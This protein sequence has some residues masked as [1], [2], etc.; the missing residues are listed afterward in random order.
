M[1]AMTAKTKNRDQRMLLTSSRR[2][3][4]VLPAVVLV[5]IAVLALVALS[6]F[7]FR[8]EPGPQQVATIQKELPTEPIVKAEKQQTPEQ[9]TTTE[10]EPSKQQTTEPKKEVVPQQ[11]KTPG[12]PPRSRRSEEPTIKLGQ[13]APDFELPRLTIEPDSQ[14]KNIGKVS[15]ET[16][17]LS[18]FRGKKPAFLIFSSYT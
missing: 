15:T 5:L 14:G 2:A 12:R 4:A 7:A 3:I 8:N 10:K 13:L 16:V 11:G 17:K 1:R 18:S 9:I 6:I